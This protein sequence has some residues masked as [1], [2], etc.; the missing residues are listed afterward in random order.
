MHSYIS[1][2]FTYYLLKKESFS[3]E[4]SLFGYMI[5]Y[6]HHNYIRKFEDM[7][8]KVFEDDLKYKILKVQI[9]DMLKPENKKK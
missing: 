5:V 1:A 2:L 8:E 6:N 3:E 9:E 7:F 4:N